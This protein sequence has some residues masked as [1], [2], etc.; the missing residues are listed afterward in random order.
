MVADGCMVIV[1]S[2][3]ARTSWE[4]VCKAVVGD[5]VHMDIVLVKP[6][7]D[8]AKFCFSAYMQER[9][10]MMK[11]DESLVLDESMQNHCLN[12]TE[13]EFS[14]CMEFMQTLVEA[15]TKYDYFHT[16]FLMPAC[17]VVGSRGSRLIAGRDVKSVSDVSRIFCS[18]SVVLM[19]RE[20][21]NEQGLHG[22]MVQEL[23]GMNS[24]LASPQMV[25]K[26][27]E[28]HSPSCWSMDNE[29][30]KR[31]CDAKRKP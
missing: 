30:L 17:S 31:L 21:L 12:I 20:C 23:R 9:F 11:M 6:G 24:T 1:R 26:V 28:R 15:R 3:F 5:P 7:T 4:K 18:Q 19:L 25:L 27:L 29:E 22:S 8:S 13:E 10:Q 14:S 2:R 16:L